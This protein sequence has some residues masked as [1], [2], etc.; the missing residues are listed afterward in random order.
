MVKMNL[1]V[2][3]VRLKSARKL[4][5]RTL[6]DVATSVG[7]NKSTI[8]RYEAGLIQSPKMPVLREV[9][10]YL[11]VNLDWLTGDS[12]E[13]ELLTTEDDLEHYL[14][15]LETR[16]EVRALLKSVDGAK[17]EDV[18]AVMD[19]FTALRSNEP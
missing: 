12:E 7:M 8:Q 19:F 1:E 9:A 10:R 15:M 18:K 4:R 6:D 3:A 17:P 5:R 13:M 2:L 14:E 11:N 16:P